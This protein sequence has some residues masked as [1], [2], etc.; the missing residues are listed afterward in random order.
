MKSAKTNTK[1]I[2]LIGLMTAILCI[3]APFSIPIGVIPI[4]I[5]NFVLFLSIYILGMKRAFICCGLY[6]LIGICGLPVFSGFS[7]GVYKFFGPT[8][9]YL[10]GFLGMVA[11]SGYIIDRFPKNRI[12]TIFSMIIGMSFCYGVG[13]IWL[14]MQMHMTFLQGLYAGVFPFILGDLVKIIIISILGPMLQE[15]LRK[16]GI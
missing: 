5:T 7:G 11:I 1:S 4:S 16:A 8:G 13:T 3:L 10:I 6:L 9:G 15:R 14:C 2:T 12:F